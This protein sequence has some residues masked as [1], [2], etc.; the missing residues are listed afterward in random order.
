MELNVLDFV[1]LGILAFF[2]VA[3]YIKGFIAQVLQIIAIVVAFV[4]AAKFYVPRAD[5]DLFRGVRENN[6][7]AAQVISFVGLFFVSGAVLS[8]LASVIS[9]RF[10]N[11]HMKSGDRMLGAVLAT[12]KGVLIVGGVALGLRNWQMGEHVGDRFGV[13]QEHREA[14]EN[15]V[16]TSALVPRLADACLTLVALIPQSG[17]EKVREL[18][19]K[20]TGGDG[21]GDPGGTTKSLDPGTPLVAD[22][23]ADKPASDET[24]AERRPLLDFVSLKALWKQSMEA[25]PVPASG[26]V[27]DGD[28]P[29]D[30]GDT[31]TP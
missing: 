29:S 20:N 28:D 5:N 31:K 22:D 9:K 8:F 19:E 18:W 3:G 16:T 11:E 26:P 23:A 30:G 6:A 7:G 15:L 17:Q 25:K 1:L 24:T 27:D 4:L 2:L 13:R 21:Q 12:A 14:A 10:R